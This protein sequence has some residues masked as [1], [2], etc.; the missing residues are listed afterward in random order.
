MRLSTSASSGVGY[1][2]SND[3]GQTWRSGLLPGLTG[4]SVPSGVNER[5][6]DPAVTYDARHGTWHDRFAQI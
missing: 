2:V 1:A 6:S 5:A 4:D 3:S